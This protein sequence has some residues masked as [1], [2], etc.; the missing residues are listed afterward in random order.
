MGGS[1][2]W[3]RP[4]DFSPFSFF[5]F[6]LVFLLAFMGCAL[7]KYLLVSISPS[8]DMLFWDTDDSLFQ[9]ERGGAASRAERGSGGEGEESG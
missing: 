2:E 3:R 5:L 8:W 9:V 1:R 7:V 6:R 4:G